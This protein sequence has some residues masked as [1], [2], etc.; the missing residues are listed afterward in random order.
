VTAAV[1]QT[2]EL[3][4]K[5]VALEEKKATHQA[6]IANANEKKAKLESIVTTREMQ[7]WCATFT[8]DATG[9]T[10]TIEID[11]VS[12]TQI[13][14][15]ECKPWTTA[16]GDYR[17]GLAMSGAATYLA[18]CLLPAWQR[19]KPTYRAGVISEIDRTEHTCTVT[20]DETVSP[21][22]DLPINKWDTM[23]NVPIEYLDCNS[24][25]F[26]DGDRV[27]VQFVNQDW[28]QP[29][30]IGFESNPKPCTEWLWACVNESNVPLEGIRKWT[31]K[32][33]PETLVAEE[34]WT[35]GSLLSVGIARRLLD[36]PLTRNI[37]G[38]L[39]DPTTRPATIYWRPDHTHDQ[40]DY[41]ASVQ[42]SLNRR[43]GRMLNALYGEFSFPDPANDGDRLYDW[44]DGNFIRRLT[45]PFDLVFPNGSFEGGGGAQSAINDAGQSFIFAL[46]A[47][48]GDAGFTMTV[49]RYDPQGIPVVWGIA[50]P[51]KEVVVVRGAAATNDYVAICAPTLLAQNIWLIDPT[52]LSPVNSIT[53]TS[54][55][56]A[57]RDV[58]IRGDKL[59]V[60]AAKS[61]TAPNAFGEDVFV[62]ADH[63]VEEY[64]LPD[65]SFV[66]RTQIAGWP[67]FA[68]STNDLGSID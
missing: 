35:S 60:V 2:K 36:A 7:A 61:N 68:L 56:Y 27:V 66:R 14:I 48:F 40:D 42:M 17:H 44:P 49:A 8:E 24:G 62:S 55:N 25:P 65:L 51:E 20:L 16:D 28:E 9:V 11:G 15:P 39:V 38:S 53:D 41:G 21:A 1:N 59:F 23:F 43:A 52:N 45:Q 33:N 18:E 58:A 67:S 30:V 10:G 54:Y 5:L 46:I 13:L 47:F 37:D 57:W 19:Y 3:A 63:F 29:K 12:M 32:I 26:E 22:Q 34:V 6:E 64:T 4:A 50:G 31:A